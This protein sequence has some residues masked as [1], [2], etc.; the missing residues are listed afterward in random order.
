[1]TSGNVY[2]LERNPPATREELPFRPTTSDKFDGLRSFTV[3][4]GHGNGAAMGGKV[5]RIYFIDEHEREAVVR[6]FLDANPQLIEAKSRRSLVGAIGG[7]GRSWRAAARTVIGEFYDDESQS[8]NNEGF[9]G[10][11]KECS[12]CGESVSINRYPNHL[13]NECEATN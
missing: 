1:M 6:A 11:E 3:R 8:T 9:Q 5:T 13:A 4:G 12:L 10:G 7:H 2:H